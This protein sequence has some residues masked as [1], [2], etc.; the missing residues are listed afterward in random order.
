MSRLTDLISTFISYESVGIETLRLSFSLIG[1]PLVTVTYVLGLH[2]LP[3]FVYPVLHLLELLKLSSAPLVCKICAKES[4]IVGL[5]VT[6][7]L[8]SGS[9][10]LYVMPK[11]SAKALNEHKTEPNRTNITAKSLH[12]SFFIFF[13]LYFIMTLFA[14]DYIL[15]KMLRQVLF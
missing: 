8:P 3:T 12:L 1:L 9:P 6:L 2:S 13:P 11:L 7:S 15:I 10:P 4:T 14:Y 5:I